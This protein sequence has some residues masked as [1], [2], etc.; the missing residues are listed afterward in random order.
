MHKKDSKNKSYNGCYFR[1]IRD[2]ENK[3]YNDDIFARIRVL[4]VF[5]LCVLMLF[6]TNHAKMTIKKKKM[7]I[8]NWNLNTLQQKRIIC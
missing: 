5:F 2:K 6:S 8:L 4:T 3:I 7:L 1:V